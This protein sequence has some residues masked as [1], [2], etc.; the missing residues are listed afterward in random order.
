MGAKI[1]TEKDFWQCSGGNMPAPMQST[2]LVARKQDGHKYITINDKSTQSFVDFACK[3]LMWLMALV[4]AV[5]A[6]CVVATGGAALIAIGAIAGAAGAVFG[7]V[8][9][10]L[11]CGQKAAMARHWIG[12]KDNL[13]ILGTPTVTGAHKMVCSI[14][15]EEI[16]FAPN[17]KSWWQAVALGAANFIG[18]VLQGAMVGAAVGGGAALIQGGVAALAEGGVSG[19]GRGAL[20]LVKSLPGNVVGNVVSSWATG[21][22][23]GLRGLLGA[24]NVAA[25]YGET[26]QAGVGDFASGAVSM[27]TGTVQ[28]AKNVFTG[29]GTASDYLGL[30]LWM[31]PIHESTKPKSAPAEEGGGGKG[32]PEGD[33]P[34]EE[35]APK[36]EGP[37]AETPAEGK[38]GEAFEDNKELN[39]KQTGDAGEAAVIDKLKK[40]GYDEILQIQNN[41]GHGVDVIGRNSKTGDVKCIEVKANTSQL[42]ADQAKGG[43]WYVNDRLKK[44]ASGAPYYRVPPNPADL[45]TN[46]KLAQRWIQNAPNVDYEVHRVDVDR[47]NGNVGNIKVSPWDAPKPE[48]EGTGGD[49]TG[50]GGDATGDAVEAPQG[51]GSAGDH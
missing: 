11:I 25:T 48:G 31:T 24:Q 13:K 29:Q 7:A 3:K 10:S 8:V 5:I 35:E 22:G 12:Q 41:S 51:A 26:G 18:G 45:P 37:Q 49:A 42:S 20:Q 14:F 2:Q 43:E 27:E 44:A 23:L 50:A 17:I 36:T 46:A 1:I 39:D 33:K 21:M 38:N 32:Q 6:V 4:A 9:G 15:N 16:T 40:E 34:S 28:S 19:L 30:A 47:S